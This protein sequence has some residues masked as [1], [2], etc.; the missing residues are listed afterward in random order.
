MVEK[1]YGVDIDDQITPIM[2]RNA[3]GECFWQAH[4]ADSGIASN[5]KEMSRKYCQS[6]V[7]KAFGDT[8]GDFK[9]PTKESILK[10]LEN[11]AEFSKNF[12]DQSIIQKHYEGIMKLVDKL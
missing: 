1:I 5:E 6:I 4:C 10:C 2:V 3:I 7:E 11:L 12:R 9:S 8:G